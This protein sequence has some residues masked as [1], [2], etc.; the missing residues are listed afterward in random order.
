MSQN[1]RGLCVSVSLGESRKG[2]RGN[3]VCEGLESDC[4]GL[5]K[6]VHE[7]QYTHVWGGCFLWGWF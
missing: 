2:A 6:D 7:S 3:C 4:L 5:G 1:K